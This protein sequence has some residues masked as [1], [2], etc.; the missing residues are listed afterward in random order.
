MVA[1]STYAER[2]QYRSNR[3]HDPTK[4]TD[5][6]DGTHY[7]SLLG[8]YVTIDDEQLPMQF[9]SDPR[10]IALGLSTDGFGPFKHRNKTAWPLILFNYN[11]SPE[12][13]FRKKHIIPL[14]TIPGPKK[15]L[16]LDSFLWPVVQELLQLKIG[17]LAFDAHLQTTFTLHAYL[18][19]VFGDIPAVSMIMRMKGHNA[20]APCRMCEIQGIRKPGTNTHYVPLDRS[21][22]PGSQDSYDPSVLPLRD[23]ASFLEQAEMVQ[24]A[25]TS[26]DFD[27]LST[28]FGIK[29]LPLLSALSSLSLPISFPYDFM[30]L[31]WANLIPNLILLW[32][33]KF[34]D[35]DHNGQDYVI[36][37]TVWNAIGEATFRAGETIP[38]ALGSRVP[39]IA[40][41]KAHMIAE[42]YSIW[43]LYFA[44][45]LLKGRFLDER[46][47]KHFMELVRL[48]THCIDLEITQEQVDDLDQSFQKWVRDYELYVL[49]PQAVC[50]TQMEQNLITCQVLLS[51]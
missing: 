51:T 43:T 40:L 5:I 12:E 20:I 22:F 19:V 45:V 42:T 16:D 36:M 1:N 18:I 7:T 35:L 39:N 41:E 37:R 24:S 28:M 14:G 38:A 13:R 44:P 29:G 8:K 49:P 25:S 47:Y 33:G 3:T 34:K 48:L 4:L 23:H 31:I 17:V 32:T 11:L 6:F 9:F 15:P 26:K 50:V 30:H 46:Y 2:M 21:S 27:R 10:D